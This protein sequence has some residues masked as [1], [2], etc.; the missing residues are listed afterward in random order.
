MMNRNNNQRVLNRIAKKTLRTKKEFNIITIIAI[1]L[2]T[3]M[4]TTIFTIGFTLLKSAAQYNIG[5]T[6]DM[7]G[8]LICGSAIIAILISG[9]LI[10]SNIFQTSIQQ[11]I[12]FYGLIKTIGATKKQIGS[13]IRRI[14]FRLCLIGI[15]LGLIVGYVIGIIVVPMLLVSLGTNITISFNPLIFLGAA[16]FSLT[17]VFLSTYK[18]ARIAGKVSPI[19]ALKYVEI[20]SMKK[21]T[22]KRTS[23][24][25]TPQ[26][27]ASNNMKKNQK[28]SVRVI[29][30]VTLGLTLMN[31]FY[32]LQNSYDAD[33]Y[34][35]SF[36]EHDIAIF[37]TE[38][39]PEGINHHV[40]DDLR[41]HPNVTNIGEVYYVETKEK[42]N[43]DV[44]NKLFTYYDNEDN[45]ASIWLENDQDAKIQYQELK[46]TGMT[47]VS[48]YGLSDFTASMGTTYLGEVDVTKFM[49]GKYVIGYGIAN[50]GEGSVHYNVGDPITLNGE[51]YELMALVEPPQ[52]LDRQLV[53][54]ANKLGISYA[55]SVNN[56]HSSYFNGAIAG[57]FMNTDRQNINADIEKE[58]PDFHVASKESYYLQFQKQILA[59]VILGYTLGV[60]MAVVGILNFINAMLSSIISRKREF[61]VLESI[62]MTKKQIKSMLIYEGVNYATIIIMLSLVLA[63]LI[64]MTV[65]ENMVSTSWVAAYKFTLLPFVVII[66]LLLGLAYFIPLSCFKNTQSKSLTERLRET[67]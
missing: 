2:T 54:E 52:T 51:D 16:L 32:V 35:D 31:S 6:L 3:I 39:A 26:I 15:P 56:F 40:I 63:S 60:I 22:S 30:S 13:I 58:Y 38:D 29:L 10:I 4:F 36:L 65:I 42:I 9:Y 19:Q 24:K 62:G 11:D 8:I 44:K 5:F 47:T 27:M 14:A 12:Q 45:G 50:N 61:A 49:S 37:S 25:L 57:V 21:R 64:S 18:S 66:P 53:T 43:E 17:T 1:A 55:V 59:Q 33:K 46:N 34:V 67:T 28:L 48:V 7:Q 41:S 20:D 23:F